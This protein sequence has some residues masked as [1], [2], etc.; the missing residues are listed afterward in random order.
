[1]VR[2]GPGCPARVMAIRAKPRD[3]MREMT[4][5]TLLLD[6]N[7]D[8]LT[9]AE[10]AGMFRVD[11]KTPNRWSR[12]PDPNRRLHSIRTP[13]GHHRFL[14]V[15]VVAVLDPTPENVARWRVVAAE[16]GLPAGM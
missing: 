2:A 15:Q 11:P 14:R 8:L 13:G 4:V 10:V 1:M 9:S 16:R 7:N 6:D 12:K 3:D 5:A